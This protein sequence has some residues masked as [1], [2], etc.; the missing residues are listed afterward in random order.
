MVTEDNDTFLFGGRH[1]YKNLFDANRHVEMYHMADVETE[2]GVDRRKLVD[3]ALLLGSDYTDG[4]HGIGIV[5]AMEVISAFGEPAG[6]LA[7][8]GVWARS[9]SQDGPETTEGD[10]ERLRNFKRKHRSLRRNWELSDGFPSAQVRKPCCMAT[11]QLAQRQARPPLAAARWST[12]TCGLTWTAMISLSSGP[13]PICMGCDSLLLP[14]LVGARPK[15]TSC[16]C[17]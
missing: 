8:F 15:R 11:P 6:G 17:R 14:N 9:W 2:I 16:C 12:L 4:V 7:A 10:S 13:D 1:I 5:N 3:L